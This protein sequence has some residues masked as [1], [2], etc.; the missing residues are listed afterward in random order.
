ML[1]NVINLLGNS[2]DFFKIMVVAMTP[3]GE[4]RASIPLGIIKLDAPLF[5]VFTASLLGNL[6]PIVLILLFLDKAD[7]LLREKS[8]RA[9]KFFDWL[10][11]HTYKKGGKQFEKWGKIALIF[12]VAIPLPL[13][14][15]W[16]GSILALIFDIPFKEAL[17]LIATGVLISGIIVTFLTL[18]IVTGLS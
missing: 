8:K 16:T 5:T 3:F 11:Q 2:P 14:G 18:S 15:A 10:Y 13:T 4:L 9:A 6:I 12:F 17:S 7:N 1:D